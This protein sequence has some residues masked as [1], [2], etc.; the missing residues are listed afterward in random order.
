MKQ[1]IFILLCGMMLACGGSDGGK[2]GDQVRLNYSI[3]TVMVHPG[4]EILYVNSSLYQAQLSKDKKHL[5]NFNHTEF[6]IEKINLDDLAFE[7]KIMLSKEGPD[8]VGQYFYGF[9]LKD[10][11]SLLVRCYN[12]DNIV[13]FN[14]KKKSQI[15]FKKLGDET[16]K[17]SDTESLISAVLV[18]EQT[19]VY[20]GLISSWE[21]GN[22][23]V[24]K[25]HVEED[26]IQRFDIPIFEK[27]KKFEIEIADGGRFTMAKYIINAGDKLI[28]G[29]EGTNEMYVLDKDTGAARHHEYTSELTAI[30]KTGNYPSQVGGIE[31]FSGIYR[32]ILE[33][34]GFLPPVW[35]EVNEMYYRFSFIMEFDDNAEKPEG[36]PFQQPSGAKVFLTVYDKDLNMLAESAIPQMKNRPPFHFAKEGKLW[37]FENIEDEMGFVQFG[38]DL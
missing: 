19:D 27:A 20:Y 30:E 11:N 37:V 25:I 8:G 36:S 29:V 31:E 14:G 23:E 38:F 22:T 10:E 34:V 28:V 17:L 4:Q 35:D 26:K 18:P 5:Y 15:D 3:D 2:N 7:E 24:A 1:S 33:E 13:D 12:Q 21:E 6:A 16:E 32:R 9:L